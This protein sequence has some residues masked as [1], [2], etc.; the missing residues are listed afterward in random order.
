MKVDDL[1]PDVL[2]ELF[3]LSRGADTEDDDRSEVQV[4]YT[5]KWSNYF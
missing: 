1:V 2:G 5:T 4:Y 3:V